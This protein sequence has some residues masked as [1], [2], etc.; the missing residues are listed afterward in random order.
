VVIRL[1]SE[2]AMNQM[3]KA[4]NPHEQWKACGVGQNFYNDCS[5]LIIILL[6]RMSL[7]LTQYFF[8]FSCRFEEQ[9]AKRWEH[10]CAIARRVKTFLVTRYRRNDSAKSVPLLT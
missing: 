5:G 6:L 3:K 4:V 10:P 8:Q 7:C 9:R 1:I 2:G